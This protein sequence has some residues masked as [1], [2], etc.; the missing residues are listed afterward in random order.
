[1]LKNTDKSKICNCEIPF[2]KEILQSHIN[3]SFCQKCGSILIKSVSG[4]IYYTIKPIKKQKEIEL[5]PITII[6]SMKRKTEENFPHIYNSYNYCDS[7]HNS[8]NEEKL[9]IYLKNRK[10][11]ILKLQKLYKIFDFC[12]M[13]FFQCLFYLDTYLRNDIYE[14]MSEKTLLYN[15]VGYFLCSVKL[16]EKDIC[17][18]P[19]ESF[20]NISKNIYLSPTKIA[21]YEEFCLKRINYNIFIYSAYDWITQLISNGIIFNNEID[22][23]NE[24]IHING[25]R[26]TLVNVLNKFC[27]KLLL[28]LTTKNCFFKYSP[29]YIALSIIKLSREKYINKNMIKTKL[30]HKLL[31]L[32]GVNHSSFKECYEELKSELNSENEINSKEEIKNNEENQKPETLVNEQ[33]RYSVDKI[34]KSLKSILKKKNNN[35]STECL[36]SKQVTNYTSFHDDIAENSNQKNNLDNTNEIHKRNKTL[37]TNINHLSIDCNKSSKDSLPKVHL[38]HKIKND[39]INIEIIK[40]K[41]NNFISNTKG[42]RNNIKKEIYHNTELESKKSRP[43]KKYLT[44]NKLTRVYIDENNEHKNSHNHNQLEQIKEVIHVNKNKKYILK[45]DKNLFFNDLSNFADKVFS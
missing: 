21:H 38:K 36:S 29:M 6:K 27:M 16:G 12:D 35:L 25:H 32:Y 30:F 15:L 20:F 45:S 7:L 33:Q 18:P 31:D 41:D 26:H 34:P 5:D 22:E 13:T 44:T 4:N 1:M 9:N 3:H 39:E 43:K 40:D 8:I 17:E 37:L 11:L 10:T 24:I 23:N 42:I 28:R 2:N 14:N 19:L